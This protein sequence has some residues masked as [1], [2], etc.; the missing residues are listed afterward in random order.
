MANYNCTGSPDNAYGAGAYDTCT[1]EAAGA[2]NTGYFQQVTDSASFTI[3]APLVTMIVVALI[4]SFV[5]R[6]RTRTHR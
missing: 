4:A 6:K 2:P 3:I 1:T 5:V